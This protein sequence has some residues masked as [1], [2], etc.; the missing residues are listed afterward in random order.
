MCF[1]LRP[2]HR[3]SPR[4]D[5]A[6]ELFAK[7]P[8]ARIVFYS[9][10][11]QDHIVRE[12]Y[13]IGGKAFVPKSAPPQVLADAII[14]AAAGTTYFLP[15]IAERIALMSVRGEEAPQVKL[16]ERELVV[17]KLMAQGLTNAEIA[18]ELR[19][20]SKTIGIITQAVKESLGVSRPA[21]I[22]RLALKHQLIDE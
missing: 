13:R 11:D 18:K 20:S 4:L 2:A 15:E 8:E 3:V 16:S 10:F 17:F 5:V 12:A 21:D 19:L 7:R 14:A 6:R 1:V 22:T 9:Q